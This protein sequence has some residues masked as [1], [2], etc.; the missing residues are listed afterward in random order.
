L[1]RVISKARQ[2]R[3]SHAAKLGRNVTVEEV[4]EATGVDRG[5]LTRLETGKTERFD[6]PMI[7]KLCAYYGVGVGDILVYVEGD[8]KNEA[9]GLMVP[10]YAIA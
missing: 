4:A 1:G 3:L 7:A 5:A 8:E 9:P 10:T 2:T 6:G